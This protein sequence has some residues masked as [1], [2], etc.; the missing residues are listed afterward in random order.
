LNVNAVVKY[1]KYAEAAIKGRSI[2]QKNAKR[3]DILKDI[4][5]HKKNIKG[6]KTE[7]KK[8]MKQLNGVVKVNQNIKV[9]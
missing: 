9:C 3:L 6:Q 7:K 4:E 5:R 8:G 1:L 2:V